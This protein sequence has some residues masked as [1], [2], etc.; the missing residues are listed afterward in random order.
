MIAWE[1]ELYCTQSCY[2]WSHSLEIDHLTFKHTIQSREIYESRYQRI[3][4]DFSE[5]LPSIDNAFNEN[6]FSNHIKRHHL[7]QCKCLNS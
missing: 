3:H 1:D 5:R 4:H 7:F 2:I 6:W